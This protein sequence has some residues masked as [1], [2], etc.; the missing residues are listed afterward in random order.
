MLTSCLSWWLKGPLRSSGPR[1]DTQALKADGGSTPSAT[2]TRPNHSTPGD[3]STAGHV[4]TPL[5]EQLSA[6]DEGSTQAANLVADR[7]NKALIVQ[8]PHNNLG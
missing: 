3:T 5:G 1:L 2:H 7:V 6:V 8:V 4:R